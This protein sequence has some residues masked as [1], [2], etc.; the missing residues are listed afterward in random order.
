MAIRYLALLGSCVLLVA[1]GK[2]PETATHS[3]ETP[4]SGQTAIVS[5]ASGE[6]PA[7]A[8]QNNCTACHAID[9]K[10]VG[11]SWKDVAARYKGQADAEAKLIAKVSKGGGGVWGS[12]PMPANDA[13]GHKQD[14]MRELVRFILAL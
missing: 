5:V 10:V 12:M 14:Q 11:P 8:K 2:S 9:K 1:C 3:V 7:I 4:A 13:S 6:M